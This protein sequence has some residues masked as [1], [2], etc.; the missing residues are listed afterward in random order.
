MPPDAPGSPTLAQVGGAGNNGAARDPSPAER[1]RE[2]IVEAA[3]AVIAEEGLHRLSLARIESRLAMSRGQL[4]YYFPT[5]ESI[6]LAVF[7]RML[8]QMIA[9]ATETARRLGV[10]DAGP[11]F[12][13]ERTRHGLGGL[14]AHAGTPGELGGG[15][16]HALSHTFLAQVSHRADY[17]AKLAAAFAGWRQSI[18]ADLQVSAQLSEH[19]AQA[20]ASVVMAMFQGLGDQ[21]RVDPGAFDRASALEFILGA[22]RPGLT[23]ADVTSSETRTEG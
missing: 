17:R 18:A 13:F 20:R 5:K 9:A 1:R 8:G 22:L 6:L 10:A 23:R 7:D 15:H 12:A 14:M 19:D 16:L 4:T 21:L 11:D 2:E 3:T